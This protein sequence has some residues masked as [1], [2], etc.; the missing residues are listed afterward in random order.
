MNKWLKRLGSIISAALVG[1]ACVS[2]VSVLAAGAAG[3]YVQI[4][5]DNNPYTFE[6]TAENPIITFAAKFDMTTGGPEDF[7][8][9]WSASDVDGKECGTEI[10]FASW[11]DKRIT[12]RNRVAGS[13]ANS[14]NINETTIQTTISG[15][16]FADWHT[17]RIVGT[18]GVSVEI[19]IDGK[20]IYTYKETA[21]FGTG[22][23]IRRRGYSASNA[24]YTSC[25][26][27]M[28]IADGTEDGASYTEDFEDG[29]WNGLTPEITDETATITFPKIETGDTE[30]PAF[31]PDVE[32]T[33]RAAESLSLSWTAAEDGITAADAITYKVYA[34]TNGFNQTLPEDA[35]P[36]LT[37]T[38]QTS[39]VIGG[40][41]PDT[42]Y[43]IAIAAE[44][45]AGNVSVW[46]SANTVSTTPANTSTGQLTI[47]AEVGVS[48]TLSIPTAMGTITAAGDHEAGTLYASDLTLGEGDKLTV[49]AEHDDALTHTNNTDTL[50]YVLNS[51]AHGSEEK[52]AY[53]SVAFTS[54]SATGIEGGTDLYVSIS[55]EDWNAAAAGTYTDTVTFRVAYT[56]GE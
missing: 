36:A 2:S 35:Q 23:G 9:I 13:T 24:K 6:K 38:G 12:L 42:A 11:S 37:V 20:S 27:N 45:A 44:D 4:A 47:T 5:N 19:F 56:S 55:Q 7:W 3:T 1:A 33:A 30:A 32:V 49:T 29:I 16:S 14:V 26:D 41:T 34:S 40:L 8:R 17:Y 15:F 18:K 54:E 50:A 31:A 22:T 53:Q 28:T 10:V 48:Y 52:A 39:G 21:N 46:F 43:Y 25:Y 51:A